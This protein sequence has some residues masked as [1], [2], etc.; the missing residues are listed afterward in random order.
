MNK[1]SMQKITVIVAGKSE[2]QVIPGHMDNAGRRICLQN[3]DSS[4][5]NTKVA[6]YSINVDGACS[7]RWVYKKAAGGRWAKQ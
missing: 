3:Y 1:K 7:G 5:G 2:P 6:F 4:P